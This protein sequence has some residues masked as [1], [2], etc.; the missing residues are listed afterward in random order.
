MCR[1]S[2]TVYKQ[3]AQVEM[4]EYNTMTIIYAHLHLK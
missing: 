1:L 4:I 3:E 2:T